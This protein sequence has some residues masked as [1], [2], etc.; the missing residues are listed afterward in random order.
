VDPIWLKSR[1]RIR[2]LL[3]FIEPVPVQRTRPYAFKDI[4][5][6]PVLRAPKGKNSIL[7][8]DGV[9]FHLFGKW[10]PDAK[11]AASPP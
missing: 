2:S 9:D 3:F 8:M 5:M 10:R 11:L 6:I 7:G 4:M 1:S